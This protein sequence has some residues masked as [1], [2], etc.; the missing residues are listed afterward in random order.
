MNAHNETTTDLQ[1]LIKYKFAQVKL[2]TQALTHSSFANERQE[3]EHNER[4]EFL[5]DAILDLYVSRELFFRFPDVDE[6]KLT[7]LRAGLVNA[8]TLAELARGLRLGDYLYLGKGEESQGGRERDSLLADS[9]EALIGAIYLDGGYEAAAGFMAS[10]YQD[11]WP[12]KPE[13]PI[14]KDYKTRLQE[15]MQKEYQDRPVYTL[16]ESTGPE[17]AKVYRIRVDLPG[18][19]FVTAESSSLKKAEQAAARKGLLL[20]ESSVRS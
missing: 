18:E 16:L 12:Q 3:G 13:V 5:G 17:H 1:D 7:R 8:P 15:F 14:F 20:L 10:L 9:L 19:Q 6:G 4:L 2:L 11:M